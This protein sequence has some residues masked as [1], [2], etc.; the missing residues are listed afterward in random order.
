PGIEAGRE[1]PAKRWHGLAET[2]DS[3][4]RLDPLRVALSAPGLDSRG[5]PASFGVPAAVVCRYLRR[6]GIAP[7]RTGD[8]RFLLLFPQGARAEHAQP[9]VDRLCEF[10][11]RHDDDAPLKQVLPEL[12]DSSPLYRY[13]GLRELCAMIHEASLRLH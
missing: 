2:L 8:Y 4:P 12:L 3:S 10:K 11:R 1:T 7:L 5:C 9:L 13:I 6:H